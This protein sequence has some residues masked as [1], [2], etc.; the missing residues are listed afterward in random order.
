MD[1]FIDFTIDTSN[2]PPAQM[3][4]MLEQYQKRWIPIVD[5]GIGKDHN[6]YYNNSKDM[7]IYVTDPDGKLLIGYVWPGESTY[8]DWFNPNT[9]TFWQNGLSQLHSQIPFSGIWLDMNEA[10]NFVAG[11]LNWNPHGNSI[12]NNPPYNPSKPGDYIYDQTMRMDGTHYNGFVEY[13]VHNFD[14]FLESQAT[15]E[16]L[17]SLSNLTFI[18]SRSTFYGS[19]QFAAHWTGDNVATFEFLYLANPGIMNFNIFGIPMVGPDICGFEDNTTVE[20]CSRWY[21]ASTLYPFSRNHAADD[22]LN[23]EP[24]AL[25]PTVLETARLALDMRY[26]LLK[27]YYAIYLK[28]N[29]TGTVFKPMFFNFPNDFT[30]Y[31]Q[32]LDYVDTQYMVADCLM[33]APVVTEGAT[34]IEVYFPQATWYDFSNG[35]LILLSNQSS[36]YVNY[37]NNL[38]ETVPMF[39]LGG[40]VLGQQN[41]TG[42][43]RTDDLSSNFNLV[44]ALERQ[45]TVGPITTYVASGDLIG[46]SNLNDSNIVVKCVPYNC[47]YNVFANFTLST[48][49]DYGLVLTFLMPNN[50]LQGEVVYVEQVTLF[51]DWSSNDADELAQSLNAGFGEIDA[52]IAFDYLVERGVGTTLNIVPANPIALS[53]GKIVTLTGVTDIHI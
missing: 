29:G 28:L 22:T 8:P 53:P 17:L 32:S 15:H 7:N 14:G 23:H 37:T 27:H 31:N 51:G 20:L 13:Y 44:V 42:V 43:N 5:L 9:S 49:G 52:E 21:Q 10:S 30:F 25:G 35:N 1:H 47:V 6:P 41:V 4:A 18:L 34:S 24:Y 26:S 40:Y 46:V 45:A 2:F 38:N 33:I 48:N 3:I 11:Q 50:I 12:L 39:M 19:N 36:I 16:F